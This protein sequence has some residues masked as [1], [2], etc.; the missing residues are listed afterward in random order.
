MIIRDEEESLLFISSKSNV[1]SSEK[2]DLCLWTDCKSLVQ[3]FLGAFKGLWINSTDIQKC[4]DELE[5]GVITS[6]TCGIDDAELARKKYEDTIN[7]AKQS[8]LIITSPEGLVRYSEC[9]ERLKEWASKGLS[10]KIMAPITAQNYEKAKMLTGVCIVRHIPDSFSRVITL[11][12]GK[13]LFQFDRPI[14]T[15]EKKEVMPFTGYSDN[16]E[17]VK[18]TEKMLND[19]WKNS[20][21]PSPSTLEPIL[22]E[23]AVPVSPALM[24]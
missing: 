8:I 11:V 17:Y 3:A 10:V 22:R 24:G 6:Q 2:D 23:T 5:A 14:P 18:K 7:L 15:H 16:P 9:T 4:M 19:L 12:D 20:L 1:F 21:I 13:Y